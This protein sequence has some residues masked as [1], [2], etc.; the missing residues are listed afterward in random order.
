ML[1]MMLIILVTFLVLQAPLAVLGADNLRTRSLADPK[2]TEEKKLPSSQGLDFSNLRAVAFGSSRTWGAAI[3]DPDHDSYPA[4]LRAKNLAIRASGPEY[5]ALCTYSMIG[6]DEI[7]DVII[8]EFMLDWVSGAL[9]VLAARLRQRFPDSTIIFLNVWSPRQYLYKPTQKTLNTVIRDHIQSP[10]VSPI[11]TNEDLVTLLDGTKSDDWDFNPYDRKVIE[12][13]ARSVGGY[14]LDLPND[15][16]PITALK[17]YGPLFVQDMSHFSVPGHQ[18]VH[19]RIIEI[20]QTAN[21][22]TS[23]RVAPWE[24]TDHCT[25]WF[26]TGKTDLVTNMEMVDMNKDGKKFALEA[27]SDVQDNFIELN[28][29]WSQTANLYVSYMSYGPEQKYPKALLEVKQ[30][31]QNTAS[32]HIDPIL[33]NTPNGNPLH[34]ITHR[35]VG[36][37]KPGNSKLTVR[38]MTTGQEERFRVV[39]AI[40]SPHVFGDKVM[41]AL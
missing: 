27:K 41:A 33:A 21:A 34:V 11:F 32:T 30:D 31:G 25:T 19:D 18:W 37:V 15:A 36:P 23:D 39:G 3:E 5:P 29:P 4:L 22:K 28:N 2:T 6:D 35:R 26:E 38:A 9:D 12:E 14:I 20:L 17:T 24:S 40:L 13:A 8:L 7:Y 10:S 16:D 1:E